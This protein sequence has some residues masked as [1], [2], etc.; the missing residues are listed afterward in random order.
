MKYK[1]LFQ[2]S[3]P[4]VPRPGRPHSS[5]GERAQSI[6]II[7]AAFVALLALVGLVTDVGSI[8]VSWTRLKRG[9][10][11]AAVA[12]ANNMKAAKENITTAERV[13]N[14][15]RAAKEM[16]ALN[17]IQEVDIM[18]IM[19][20]EDAFDD[21]GNP[22]A[23]SPDALLDLCPTPTGLRKMAWIEARER[24]NVYFLS[25]VGIRSYPLTL[26]SIGE[27]AMLDL[28][29]VFDTSESM[30]VDTHI[31]WDNPSAPTVGDDPAYSKEFDPG[32]CTANHACYP[33]EGAKD[34]ARS[35]INRLYPYYDR[36]AIV[37]FD[38]QAEQAF[39]VPPTGQSYTTLGLKLNG[40]MSVPGESEYALNAIT[41]N[42]RLHDD[43]D[44]A[45]LAWDQYYCNGCEG[46]YNPVFPE[47]RDGDGQ[48]ADIGDCT[49]TDELA[50]P[51]RVDEAAYHDAEEKGM[52]DD[53]IEHP[54]LCD[55]DD[56]YDV[57]DWNEDWDFSNDHAAG[58]ALWTAGRYDGFTSASTC[59]GCGIRMA[60]QILAE[61]GRPGGVWV[62]VVL[63]DGAANASDN[64]YTWPVGA[65][66]EGIPSIYPYGFCTHYT[67]GGWPY[68]NYGF[69]CKDNTYAPRYC[70]DS[71][72]TTCPPSSTHTGAYFD[73]DADYH[74][75][76]TSYSA[77]DY[78]RDMTDAA[79]LLYPQ[80]QEPPVN[81][82]EPNGEDIIL[83]AITFGQD[84]AA[85]QLGLP[86]MHYIA[87]VGDDG[88]RGGE[89]SEAATTNYTQQCGNYYY[90]AD[91]AALTR[92]FSDIMARIYTK[93][94]Q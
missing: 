23:G 18:E 1:R 93:I 71:D 56:Q 13:A 36:V 3:S 32:P 52:I 46:K 87:D 34:A 54:E 72:S 73:P 69:P 83:Y 35:L 67:G 28:V 64:A 61:F 19:T 44:L 16:L 38:Y 58:Q 22:I 48:D 12:A 7:A 29:L 40:T 25:L 43:A 21:D 88:A 20:C 37:T 55:L 70:L 92:V 33:L 5:W 2:S 66:G 63:T 77:V 31:P 15:E 24:V 41:N 45:R 9:V 59:I 79:A 84:A 75:Y 85:L 49:P 26:S 6:V 74:G 80:L 14:M 47:D 10:D 8:Y 86:L 11:A 39:P 50:F 60:R 89:C 91:G 76:V 62:M 57:F 4:T 51:Y 78:A 42:I 53:F 17:G 30:G 81:D 68:W 94:S 82:A 90:A 65:S 27:A